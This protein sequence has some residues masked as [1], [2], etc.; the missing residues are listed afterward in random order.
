MS[1]FNAAPSS[2][3]AFEGLEEAAVLLVRPP[4]SLLSDSVGLAC[5]IQQQI[6]IKGYA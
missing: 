1:T 4:L 6:P 3:I 2:T 5:L